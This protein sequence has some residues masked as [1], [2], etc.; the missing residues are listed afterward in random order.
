[1]TPVEWLFDGL[2]GLTLLWL[3][4]RVV[5]GADL[6]NTVMSFIGLGILMSLAWVRLGTPDLALAEAALGGGITGALLLSALHRLRAAPPEH[7]EN[8]DK[9]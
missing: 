6:L 1:M 5:S 8:D 4:I 3:G 7:D 2:L 9:D